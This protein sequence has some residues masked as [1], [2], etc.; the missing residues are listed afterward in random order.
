MLPSSSLSIA[1]E[2]VAQFKAVLLI[3][4]TNVFRA[5]ESAFDPSLFKSEFS[6][7]QATLDLIAQPIGKPKKDKKKKAAAA[8]PE[9][10]A[11]AQ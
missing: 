11:P 6:L 8:A 4:E 1:G 2:F 5:T 10:A 3:T 9:G 7:D